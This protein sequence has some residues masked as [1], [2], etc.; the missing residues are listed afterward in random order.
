MWLIDAWL[1]SSI[2]GD[3]IGLFLHCAFD[4]VKLHSPPID[5]SQNETRNDVDD[6]VVVVKQ[7]NVTRYFLKTYTRHMS[8]VKLCVRSAKLSS[9]PMTAVFSLSPF[10]HR[11]I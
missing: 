10:I 4:V 2:A 5:Q 8:H 7:L 11:P 6:V 9:A 3:A 1:A